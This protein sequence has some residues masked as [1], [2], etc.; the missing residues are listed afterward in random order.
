MSSSRTARIIKAGRQESAT[1]QGYSFAAIAA[2]PPPFQEEQES[3]PAAD[4]F[5]PF[6][7]V[8]PPPGQGSV[9][10]AIGGEETVAAIPDL[11]GMIV[12]TEE[13][14]QAKIDEVYCNGMEEGRRQAERGLANV[15]KSLREGVS[16]LTGLRQRVLKESEEDLLRLAVMIARKIVQQ[17]IAQDPGVLASII[18]A[19]VGG[20]AERDRVVVRLNPGDHALVAANRQGFLA[21]LGEDAPI[22]LA[23][24]DG[25]GPGGCLVE[26]ITGTVDARIEAQIDEIYRTLLEERSTPVEATPV[27]AEPEQLGELSSLPDDA[28]PPYMGTGEWVKLEEEKA[29]VPA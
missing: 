1:V 23:P 27:P 5:V 15:F 25:V 21:G 17:E 28:I 3:D 2:A 4:G 11:E 18:A 9:S 29:H 16:A 20:C 7:L 12:L 24:D 19:A 14:L 10:A 8:G 22:T 26:T 6:G 13:E